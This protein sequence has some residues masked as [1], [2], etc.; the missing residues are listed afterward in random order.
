MSD[1]EMPIVIV[2]IVR[3]LSVLHST[4][5]TVRRKQMTLDFDPRSTKDKRWSPK[6]MCD[7][8][9]LIRALNCY[10]WLPMGS[11]PSM[12]SRLKHMYLS[13]PN[14]PK[15]DHTHVFILWLLRFLR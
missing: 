13:N 3:Y 11:E 5:K 12:T 2:T 10:K 14:P 8:R 1:I 4:A 15:T 6:D 7:P 9:K